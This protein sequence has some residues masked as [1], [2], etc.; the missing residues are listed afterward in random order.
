MIPV[1]KEKFKNSKIIAIHIDEKIKNEQELN[2]DCE[3]TK[4]ANS[5]CKSLYS[6]D[7][8]II[9]NFL[10][11][12]IP[13]I[14]IK[15]IRIIEWRPSLNF[16]K[17]AYVSLLSIV[18][19]YLKITDAGRRT[20]SV[21]GKRWF[22]NFFKNLKNI[23]KF[24]LYRQ[25]A[26]PVIITGSGP[27]LEQSLPFIAENQNNFIIIAA[28]S[29]VTALS[30]HGIKADI[31]IA[32][33]GGTWALKHFYP[34]YRNNQSLHAPFAPVLAVNLCAA[35]PSQSKNSDF[36]IINDGSFWQNIVLHEIG[37]PSVL[38]RQ[39]GT[40]SASAVEL[41][42]LLSS[43]NIYLAGLDFSVSDIRTHVRPY[44]FDNLFFTR[45]N[46]FNPFYTTCFTRSDLLKKGGSLDIY[47]AWFKNQY[48]LW[49]P[50][51]IFQ[52]KEQLTKKKKI[53]IDLSEFFK[54]VKVKEDPASFCKRGVYA[55]SAALKISE[56]S[57]NLLQELK[58]LLFPEEKN[59]TKQE[60][61]KELLKEINY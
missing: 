27:S 35:L 9:N 28:S 45:A 1:L 51:R 61:E 29:S 4:F 50:K 56:Y 20:T 39:T 22:K 23:N 54:T 14:D 49:P 33:D 11:Q 58:T 40:V 25:C 59:I 2:H 42:L 32:T 48:N 47:A 18:V 60:L 6:T 43:A 37:L 5:V 16:Y 34:S 7:R 24:L 31:I 10:E 53:K 17:E 3:K 57:D 52:I 21:F 12:E 26:F 46:R 15:N 13:D 19:E 36:F 8:A 44:A 38:I 55:L 30:S 41:A